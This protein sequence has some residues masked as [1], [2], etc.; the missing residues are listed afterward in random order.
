MSC[1]AAVVFAKGQ[2][3]VLLESG[4]NSGLPSASPSEPARWG[5][6]V[7][8]LPTGTS[9]LLAHSSQGYLRK[10]EERKKNDR[11]GAAAGLRPLARAP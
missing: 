2:A 11:G 5:P 9:A 3:L 6:Q 8:G 10:N 1:A 7:S 4:A